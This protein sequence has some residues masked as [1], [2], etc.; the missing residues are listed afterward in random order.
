[1]PNFW[2]ENPALKILDKS[3]ICTR[4]E[5][6][7]CFGHAKVDSQD[8]SRDDCGTGKSFIILGERGRTKME[9]VVMI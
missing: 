2:P 7:C 3:H 8:F 1:M 6:Y 5:V 4:G 9:A